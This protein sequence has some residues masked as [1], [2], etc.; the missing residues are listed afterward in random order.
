MKPTSFKNI[1]ISS[2]KVS[3]ERNGYSEVP[4]QEK[5]KYGYPL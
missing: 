4:A 2:S 5:M 1:N 3:L